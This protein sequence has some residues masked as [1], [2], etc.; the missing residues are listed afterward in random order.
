MS[1]LS[2]IKNIFSSPAPEATEQTEQEHRQ[3]ADVESYWIDPYTA[4]VTS[5]GANVTETT[6]LESVP[7][8]A[9][10]T[11]I[12]EA[13]GS[14]PFVAYRRLEPWGKERATD[15]PVY[16]LVHDEP[17]A[18]MTSQTLIETM[19][20]HCLLWGNGYA[21]IERGSDERPVGIYPLLPDRTM[22]IRIEGDLYYQS[23]VGGQLITL[24]PSEVLHI[25]GPS[26][27]GFLGIN[28]IQEAREMIGTAI[29]ADKFAGEYFGNGVQPSGAVIHPEGI[30]PKAARALRTDIETQ[31]KGLGKHH[32]V[33]V[34][35]ENCKFE[36]FAIDAEAAQLLESRRFSVEDAGRLFRVPSIML[37]HTRDSNY[38]IGEATMRWFVTNTLRPWGRRFRMEFS[39]KLFREDEQGTYF[40]EFLFDDLLTGDYQAKAAY[41][42]ELLNLGAITP[43]EI[44]E[45]EN[46]N[47]YPNGA[48]NEPIVNGAYARLSTI[49]NAQNSDFSKIHV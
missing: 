31:H 39:R 10:V 23:R 16:R 46:L 37:N 26:L 44:R 24:T 22:P 45:R 20:L 35:Q 43:S 18:D 36:P 5:S 38:S 47:P 3:I 19:T 11:C 13:L 2:N 17:N 29:A 40:C 33:L 6:A 1:L 27:N 32:K 25:V 9:A 7:I 21:Y 4:A 34:L 8:L 42:R 49:E 28:R 30:G 12:A 14:L 15:H 48:G 41:Y